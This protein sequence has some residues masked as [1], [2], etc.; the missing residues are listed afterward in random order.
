MKDQVLPNVSAIAAAGAALVRIVADGQVELST[1]L[2]ACKSRSSQRVPAHRRQRVDSRPAGC[3]FCRHVQTKMTFHTPSSNV[4]QDGTTM[5]S[6][7][8]GVR[9]RCE[10]SYALAGVP[11]V[12]DYGRQDH[13]DSGT[14]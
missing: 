1:F 7:G 4:D 13:A 6:L 5:D 3:Y 14:S 10:E 11:T 2:F 12:Q 8:I 9:Q